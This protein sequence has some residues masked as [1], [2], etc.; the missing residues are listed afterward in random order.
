M[1]KDWRADFAR[2]FV[3]ANP[4]IEMVLVCDWGRGWYYLMEPSRME[5]SCKPSLYRKK[6]IEA[7]TTRLVNRVMNEAVTE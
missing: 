6:Q 4:N 1:K 7:M 3:T 2:A 5:L